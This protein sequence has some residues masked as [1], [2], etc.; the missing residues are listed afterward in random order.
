MFAFS[1]EGS[2]GLGRLYVNNNA[3][4]RFNNQNGA[5][6]GEQRAVDIGHDI[7]RSI[8]SEAITV[9]QLF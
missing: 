5:A 7:E 6:C 2:I 3:P 8:V 1:D 9:T 4:V